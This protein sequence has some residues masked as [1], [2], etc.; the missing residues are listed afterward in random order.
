ME[1]PNPASVQATFARRSEVCTA[2]RAGEAL[3]AHSSSLLALSPAT[4]YIFYH[5]PCCER[6]SRSPLRAEKCP[7][8]FLGSRGVCRN[9]AYMGLLRHCL[10]NYCIISP[11]LP[12]IVGF[13]DVYTA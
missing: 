13:A 9:S 7:A 6:C 1:N 2:T 12:R 8:A 11:N 4:V 10:R 5:A 3:Q